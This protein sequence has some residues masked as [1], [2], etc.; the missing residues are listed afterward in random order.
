MARIL[1]VEDDPDQRLL[2]RDV[3]QYDGHET[4][5]TATVDEAEHVLNREHVDLVILDM[6]LPGRTGLEA[7][8]FIRHRPDLAALPIIVVSANPQFER[9]ADRLGTDLFLVKPVNLEA[10]RT[11]VKRCL[12]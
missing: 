12:R 2:M 11:L 8:T 1:L 4:I 7:I 6:N 10:L 3:M 5:P 9:E